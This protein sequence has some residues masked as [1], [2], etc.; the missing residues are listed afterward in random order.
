MSRPSH[1]AWNGGLHAPAGLVRKRKRKLGHQH[2][3]ASAFHLFIVFQWQ[4]LFGSANISIPVHEKPRIYCS[5]TTVGSWGVTRH[6]LNLFG[7][8]WHELKWISCYCVGNVHL[9][10]AHMDF[11]LLHLQS[12]ARHN[13]HGFHVIAFTIFGSPHILQFIL[14]MSGMLDGR[15]ATT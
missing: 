15:R 4:G 1:Y 13:S 9:A 2:S 6:L 11:M 12:S 3:A 5:N 14:D 7:R 10:T 8:R